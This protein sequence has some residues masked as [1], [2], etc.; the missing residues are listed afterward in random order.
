MPHRSVTLSQFILQQEHQHPES[1]GE[2]TALLIDLALAAKMI[3]REVTRA[4]LVDILGYSGTENVN[5]CCGI[6][7]GAAGRD[8]PGRAAAKAA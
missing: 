1:S 8:E 4:G 2:F 5:C 3:N 7:S 6:A